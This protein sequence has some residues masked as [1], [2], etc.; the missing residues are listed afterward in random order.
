[1]GGGRG[2][3]G[4]KKSQN[5]ADVICV[6]TLIKSVAAYGISYLGSVPV[7]SKSLACEKLAS[8]LS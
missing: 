7:F 8:A 5:F 4:V 6:T 1:M 3:E 2:L